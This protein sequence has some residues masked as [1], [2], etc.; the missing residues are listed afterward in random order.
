MIIVPA[1]LEKEKDILIQDINRLSPYFSRFQIDIGDGKFVNN[2]T[3]KIS[4]FV[5]SFANIQ[6]VNN[7]VFDFHLMVKDPEP[8]IEEIQKLPKCNVGIIFIHKA[9][10]LPEQAGVFGLVL[11]PE[12]EVKDLPDELI[13]SLSA[14]QIMTVYPGFQ[15]KPIMPETL[16]KI[17]Q[18]RK[19]GYG[20]EILIDGGVNEKTLPLIL[21][22][23][24]LPDV[25]CIGSYL[26]KSSPEELLSRMT[27]L[28]TMIDSKE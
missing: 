1:P 13:T 9:V 26:T 20:G 10:F 8:H 5:N 3:V 11:S 4:E 16:I 23:K 7:V 25:L 24:Y 12:D 22:Q 27:Q 18:L 17:E 21:Q 15:G 2:T 6:N 19:R 14:I 28:K